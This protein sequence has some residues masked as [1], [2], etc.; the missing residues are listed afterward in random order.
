MAEMSANG[1]SEEL[2]IAHPK[3]RSAA[4]PASAATNAAVP[5]GPDVSAAGSGSDHRRFDTTQPRN[6]IVWAS[7][8]MS[9][10]AA[11]SVAASYTVTLVGELGSNIE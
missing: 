7:V 6:A 4:T 8:D 11:S 2:R 9:S 5:S 3:A 1:R 10:I